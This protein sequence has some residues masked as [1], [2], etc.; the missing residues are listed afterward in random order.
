M[1]N[2]KFK[3]YRKNHELYG[4]IKQNFKMQC[5]ILAS[6]RKLYPTVF[7]AA[8]CNDWLSGLAESTE[9]AKQWEKDDVLD[10]KVAEGCRDCTIDT[11][12]VRQY[13][14]K[15]LY[16]L[17]YP[18]RNAEVL[19]YNVKIAL[20]H[21]AQGY[22]IGEKRMNRLLDT[23]LR[24]EMADP[25]GEVDKIKTISIES[26][27][28]AERAV[29]YR[30]YRLPKDKP[31]SLKEQKQVLDDFAEFREWARHNLPTERKIE[32]V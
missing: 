3:D 22:G 19:E 13:V 25:I 24:E 23:L 28:E 10:Y 7:T 12:K 4:I 8:V 1:T 15:R 20:I 30:N 9:E 31:E 21:T 2:R 27:E 18:K 29:D 11:D 26:E 16:G 6:L 14:S 17:H 5:E 32:N